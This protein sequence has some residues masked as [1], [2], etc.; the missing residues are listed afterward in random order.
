VPR[1]GS[2]ALLTFLTLS[3]PH[4]RQP[5][6]DRGIIMLSTTVTIGLVALYAYGKATSGW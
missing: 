5:D 3:R 2:K 6:W 1:F 4:R